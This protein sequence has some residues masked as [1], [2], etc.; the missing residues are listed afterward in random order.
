MRWKA[1]SIACGRSNLQLCHRDHSRNQ[2]H[3]RMQARLDLR[4]SL[5]DR[6]ARLGWRTTCW[7]TE[8]LHCTNKNNTTVSSQ[9]KSNWHIQCWVKELTFHHSPRYNCSRPMSSTF[10]SRIERFHD[11]EASR[12]TKHHLPLAT[13]LNVSIHPLQR[14]VHLKLKKMF[15]RISTSSVFIVFTETPHKLILTI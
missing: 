4:G 13:R 5:A 9:G 15:K 11:D 6:F 8:W 10:K 1:T 7:Y 2:Q 12:S 3:L 14:V